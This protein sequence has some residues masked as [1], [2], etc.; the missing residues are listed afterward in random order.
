MDLRGIRLRGRRWYAAA[1]ALAVLIGGGSWAAASSDAAPAVHRTDRLMTM[2]EKPGSTKKVRIDTSFFTARGGSGGRR[3]A[4]LLAH[5]FGASKA[6]LRPQAERLARD[7]YAVLTWSAR[8]FGKSTGK[9]G[10]NDPDGE[11]ADAHAAD[12][13][14]GRAPR[15][16]ARQGR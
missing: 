3:P 16:A 15:S 12:R 6:N 14:A 10:L 11:V 2:P 1:G 5:G 8:G 7:G 9:I 4:V 13:L